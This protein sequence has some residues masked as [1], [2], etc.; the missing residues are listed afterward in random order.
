MAFT[1][2]ASGILERLE[3]FVV[4]GLDEG[5]AAEPP[6]ARA[7]LLV[8]EALGRWTTAQYPGSTCQGGALDSGSRRRLSLVIHSAP[9]T[10][11]V[12]VWGFAEGD[13]RES[14]PT[15]HTAHSWVVLVRAGGSAPSL[16]SAGKRLAAAGLRPVA[17]RAGD[18]LALSLWQ[19]AAAPDG[20]PDCT[21][22]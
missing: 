7:A 18:R 13:E 4:E 21:T 3:G 14:E 19:G 2:S 9:V 15:P 5:W 22:S 10:H 12:E 8:R 1:A 11:R 17:Q 20:C 16:E 6:A